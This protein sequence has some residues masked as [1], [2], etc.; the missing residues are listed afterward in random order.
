MR[1]DLQLFSLSP[2]PAA[3]SSPD[4]I[5]ISWGIPPGLEIIDR[6]ALLKFRAGPRRSLTALRVADPRPHR[7]KE[8]FTCAL[9]FNC[10]PTSLR[11]PDRGRAHA[12]NPRRHSAPCVI[13]SIGTRY[14]IQPWAN[15]NYKRQQS[16]GARLFSFSWYNRKPRPVKKRRAPLVR[17]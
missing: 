14:Y 6:S 2:A 11:R 15:V 17:L 10:F 12:L 8:G 16:P 1:W 4:L 3:F 9:G 5:S 7:I 13:A